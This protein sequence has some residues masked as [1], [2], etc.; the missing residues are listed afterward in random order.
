MNKKKFVFFGVC[1]ILMGV[2]LGQKGRMACGFIKEAFGKGSFN[3][4]IEEIRE[5]VNA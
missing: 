2:L 4:V 1:C 5:D 3:R